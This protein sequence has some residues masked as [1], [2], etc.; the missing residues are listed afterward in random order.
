MVI[1]PLHEDGRAEIDAWTWQI[2]AEPSR[3]NNIANQVATAVNQ[4]VDHGDYILERTPEEIAERLQEGMA[5]IIPA[6]TETGEETFR[7]FMGLSRLV[8]RQYFDEFPVLE[9]GTLIANHAARTIPGS[10]Q[11]RSS[12]VVQLA[13]SLPVVTADT[14]VISTSRSR[15]S[16][17]AMERAGSVRLDRS[18]FPMIDALTCDPGCRPGEDGRL[19]GVS[20]VIATDCGD[21]I[22]CPVNQAHGGEADGLSDSCYLYTPNPDRAEEIEQRLRR[23]FNGRATVARAAIVEGV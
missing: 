10:E 5:A 14:L 2:V 13:H 8:T 6:R 18:L 15:A 16:K 1:N 11:Y 20:N 19:A 7:Y 9:S 22:A 12:H 4:S 21:C 3:L 23:R 17:V